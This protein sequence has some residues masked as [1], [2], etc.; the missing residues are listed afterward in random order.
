MFSAELPVKKLRGVY[1]FL[2]KQ[3]ET[4]TSYILTHV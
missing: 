3:I 4:L 1:I 2:L